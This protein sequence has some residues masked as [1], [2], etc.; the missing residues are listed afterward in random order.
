MK[1]PQLKKRTLSGAGIEHLMFRVQHYDDNYATFA[2]H[3]SQW[4]K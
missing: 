4:S 1:L 3:D 2:P